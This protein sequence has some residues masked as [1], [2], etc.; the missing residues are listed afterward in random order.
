MTKKE[1]EAK[2]AS[3]EK[4][5]A[6]TPETIEVPVKTDLKSKAVWNKYYGR[7]EVHFTRE[8]YENL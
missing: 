3:L 6:K 8:E 4:Q 7:W 1:L 2:V 5:L